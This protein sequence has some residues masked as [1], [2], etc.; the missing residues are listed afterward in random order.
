M[1]VSEIADLGVTRLYTRRE[2]RTRAFAGILALLC[3]SAA[4]AVGTA[5]VAVSTGT[6]PPYPIVRL[7]SLLTG[8]GPLLDLK[9]T[10]STRTFQSPVTVTLPDV[11]YVAAAL[12]AVPVFVLAFRL[13]VSAV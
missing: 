3:A 9:G 8:E 12:V 1:T 11:S 4:F 6:S 10:G 13:L 7:R 5:V 2:R